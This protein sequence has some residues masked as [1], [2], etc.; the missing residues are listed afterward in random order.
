MEI[1]LCALH[2]Q[3]AKPV[4]IMGIYRP[5]N[6]P[7]SWFSL[8][9][10]LLLELL[11]LGPIIVMGDLNADVLQQEGRLTQHLLSA[12]DLAD[13]VTPASSPTRICNTTATCLDIIAVSSEL[14]IVEYKVGS[15]AASDHLP[16]ESM[17][18]L[19][20]QKGT[21]PTPVLKR[22]Y[23][24]VNIEEFK[25]KAGRIDLSST[26]SPSV[27]ALLS[28]WHLEMIN[29]LDQLEPLRAFPMRKNKCHG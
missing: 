8:F 4:T 22:S 15:I 17:I 20:Y 23:R 18:L 26:E 6:G 12:F 5:P 19:D 9:E 28:T 24:K 27:G 21:N 7:V 29:I 10:E 25:A 13:L 1:T 14:E 3:A 16:V 2:C 11:P